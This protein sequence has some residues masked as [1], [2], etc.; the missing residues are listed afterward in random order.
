MIRILVLLTLSCSLFS[1]HLPENR[2]LISTSRD[3]ASVFGHI[4]QMW[5][6]G[7]LSQFNEIVGS[8]YVGHVASGMRDRE[9]LRVRIQAFHKLYPDIHF[10]IE[11]QF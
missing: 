6:S 10:D 11:D 5:E 8:D 1:L 7:N 2:G 9:G 4:L 3:P